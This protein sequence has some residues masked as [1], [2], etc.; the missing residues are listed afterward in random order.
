MTRPLL[1]SPQNLA[2]QFTISLNSLAA[3]F[4]TG[5][6]PSFPPTE[7]MGIFAFARNSGQ[8]AQQV[9]GR[10]GRHYQH[11]HSLKLMV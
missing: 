10:F 6:C 1:A 4:A 7:S 9:V 8:D 5:S 2:I 3:S 11:V